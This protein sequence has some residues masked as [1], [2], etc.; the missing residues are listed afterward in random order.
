MSSEADLSTNSGGCE[1]QSGVISGRLVCGLSTSS[2]LDF[3]TGLV[4]GRC[5]TTS[6]DS[7]RDSAERDREE[8]DRAA[9]ST[10]LVPAARQTAA[11]EYQTRCHRSLVS[12]IGRSAHVHPELCIFLN[13]KLIYIAP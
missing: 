4:T 3:S 13:F 10:K 6:T 12:Y 5:S 2:S 1:P 7:A 11:D 9:K 8:A